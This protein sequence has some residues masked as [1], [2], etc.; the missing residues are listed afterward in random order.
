MSD[1]QPKP[2]RVYRVK[3]A[4]GVY[5]KG[6]LIT[7]LPGTYAQILRGRGLI[8]EETPSPP[9]ALVSAPLRAPASKVS[10]APVSRQIKGYQDRS[11]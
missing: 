7:N 6:Q 9:A 4:F 11:K 2:Q 3:M 5:V 10:E 1:K 8:V